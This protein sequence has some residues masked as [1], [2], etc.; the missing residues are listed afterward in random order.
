[1][2]CYSVLPHGHEDLVITWAEASKPTQLQ[3]ISSSC[4]S[5]TQRWLSHGNNQNKHIT[6]PSSI[7][8]IWVQQISEAVNDSAVLVLWL[9]RTRCQRRLLSVNGFVTADLNPRPCSK[10]TTACW[11]YTPERHEYL[12]SEAKIERNVELLCYC[13]H[14]I[15]LLGM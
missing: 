10:Q 1:M 4:L 12:H 14:I 6:D 7:A 5:A 8:N 13:K 3:I 2:I 15:W 9:G 11:Q